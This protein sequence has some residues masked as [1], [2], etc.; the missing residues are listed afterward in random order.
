MP[1]RTILSLFKNV[2]GSEIE[3]ET[4]LACDGKTT[5]SANA[6]KKIFADLEII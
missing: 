4:A 2:I 1:V 5:Q 3:T 6:T